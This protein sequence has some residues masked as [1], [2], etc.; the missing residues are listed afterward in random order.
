MPQINTIV[1][2]IISGVLV[3]GIYSLIAMGF[4]ITYRSA[5]VFNLAY[6]QFAVLGAFLAWTFIGPP[7]S[8]RLPLPLAVF[9]IIVSAV[10]LGLLVEFLFFRRMIG[11]P[12]FASFMLSLGL[13]A[14]LHGTIM[15]VWGPES[16]VLGATVPKGPLFLGKFVLAREYLWSFGLALV[17]TLGFVYLFRRTRIGLAMRAA[18]DNQVAARCLGVSARLNSQIA[19]VI[20]ILVATI[21]GVLI[22]TVNGVSIGL[23]ELVLL[24]LAVVLVGG[25]DSLVGCVLGGLIL[26]IGSNFTSYYLSQY[27]VGVESIVSVSL[28]LLVLLIR[29][30]GLMGIKMIKRV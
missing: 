9:L 24:V 5:R 7:G 23:S 25:L 18:Y 6:G 27:L 28:M 11:R 30:D 4:V 19:W 16:R 26:A 8:P 12:L 14:L 2:L 10:G 29:P 22:A 20:C 17:A 15:L 13:L 3:G 21:G 1:Q